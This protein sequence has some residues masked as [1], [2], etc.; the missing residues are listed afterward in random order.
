MQFY[1]IGK[2]HALVFVCYAM[3]MLNLDLYPK[4]HTTIIFSHGF[5]G[6]GQNICHYT[7]R[8]R[9]GKENPRYHFV[10]GDHA[11][12]VFDYEDKDKNKVN[13]AQKRDC[14]LLG[15]AHAGAR[16][17]NPGTMILLF[18]VSRGGSS[19]LYYMGS[20]KPM[21]VAASIVESPFA[22]IEDVIEHHY[23]KYIPGKRLRQWLAQFFAYYLLP[24]FIYPGYKPKGPK[25]IDV[26]STISH[27][28]ALLL[29]CSKED[30][31]VPAISTINLYEKIKETGH[32][33]VYLL[34][35]DQGEH[36]KLLRGAEGALYQKVVHAFLQRYQYPHDQLLAREGEEY[37]EKTRLSLQE[38]AYIKK[39]LE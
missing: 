33:H 7:R 6:N 34:L 13:F 10:E 14:A 24:I 1:V 31:F 8:N 37:L 12:Y 29:V 35:L 15:Q 27:K 9:H 28:T 26:M 5:G 4:Q 2:N 36:A 21:D 38:V 39:S 23:L 20:E 18:G 25:P 32:E 22:Q 3:T 17:K 16:I 30:T 19:I 11:I